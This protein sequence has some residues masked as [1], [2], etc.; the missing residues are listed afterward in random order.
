MKTIQ[1]AHGSGGKKM[2][3]LIKETI[4]AQLGIN[5]DNGLDDAAELHVETSRLAFTTDSFVVKPLFFSGG[6]I[7]SLAVSGTVN[8]LLMKGATPKHLSLG[9]I[10]EEGFA[11]ED[12]NTILK[13]IKKHCDYAGVTIVT[14]DTKVVGKGEADGIFINTSGVGE[15]L[16]E[17]NIKGSNAKPGQA[18][19]VSGTMGEH[20]VAVM[21]KRNELDLEGNITSDAMPLTKTVLPL[22]AKFAPSVHVLR[23]PTRGGVATTLNEI[24]LDSH[25][26]I[27]IQESEL[28]VSPH[29]Q[30]VSDLLGF[31][32]LYLPC[33][34]RFL[35]IVDGDKA[36]EIVAFINAQ[37][38]N[39]KA[40]II[41]TVEKTATTGGV[42]LTT[43]TGGKRVLDLPVGEL[44]PRIC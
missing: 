14:G 37:D 6:N 19:I 32:P 24:A 4:L 44:L 21:A 20:G 40:C 35:A 26:E 28:P 13:D 17:T 9:L 22:L 27:S 39:N 3:E 18:V 25:V 10:I 7:G 34:G 2:Y 15:I 31:D 41:G 11:L 30:A 1:L 43:L 38:Q 16:P 36:N 8:D 12:L 42:M 33:E 23:D 29:V 5:T